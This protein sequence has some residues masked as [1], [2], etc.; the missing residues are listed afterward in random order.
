MDSKKRQSDNRLDVTVTGANG[1]IG[2]TLI[3]YL[4]FKNHKITGIGKDDFLSRQN[5]KWIKKDLRKNIKCELKGDVLIHLAATRKHF[6]GKQYIFENNIEVTRNILNHVSNF[7]HLIFISSSLAE[8]PIDA[9]SESK[10][11]CEDIIKKSKINYTILRLGPVFGKGDKTNFTKI[12]QMIKNEKRII[13]PNGGKQIIQPTF[14]EDV[15]DAIDSVMLNDKFFDET[16]MVV[17]KAITLK[18]FVEKTGK[19]LN[20]NVKKINIPTKILKPIVKVYQKLKKESEITVEQLENL[21]KMS[22]NSFNSDFKSTSLEESIIK[23][24]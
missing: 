22:Q 21:N 18:E 10:K 2:Q 3:R 7:K 9:Y 12:I 23:S 13:L 16:F 1:F 4:E 11:K 17:G 6:K 8:N 24:I 20:V 19:V 5:I 14:I 15:I